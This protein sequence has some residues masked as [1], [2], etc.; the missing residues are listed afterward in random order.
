MSLLDDKM[1]SLRKELPQGGTTNTRSKEDQELYKRLESSVAYGESD[2]ATSVP[3][4]DG[5]AYPQTGQLLGYEAL[6]GNVADATRPKEPV[7]QKAAKS[8]PAPSTAAVKPKSKPIRRKTRVKPPPPTGLDD[9]GDFGDD[10]GEPAFEPLTVNEQGVILNEAVMK[11]HGD[12]LSDNDIF[13]ILDEH[14]KTIRSGMP[15]KDIAQA[16]A[17]DLSRAEEGGQGI[18]N[19]DGPG[20]YGALSFWEN[21]DGGDP[22][23]FIVYGDG[24]VQVV[25]GMLFP[26]ETN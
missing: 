17:S 19:G 13:D 23:G 22:K 8:V 21:P 18:W 1:L 2:P 7:L 16:A 20:G 10:T 24:S 5:E 25:T 15:E 12:K 9:T 14:E 6:L 4:H 26:P 3:D 11:D